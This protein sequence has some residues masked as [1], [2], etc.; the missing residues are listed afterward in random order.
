MTAGFQDQNIFLN[1]SSNGAFMIPFSVI[2]AVI[3]SASV[4]SK[5]GLYTFMLAG[6]MRLSYHISVTSLAALC[7][8]TI[9]LPEEQD[10]SMVD[11]GAHT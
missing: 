8:I 7:S 3:R 5:A 4:T 11:V 6:A 10:I 2:M 1:P 9:S